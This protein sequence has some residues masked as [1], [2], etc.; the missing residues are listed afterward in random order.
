MLRRMWREYELRNKKLIVFDFDGVILDTFDFAFDLTKQL[1]QK[2]GVFPVTVREDFEEMFEDNPWRYF[3]SKGVTANTLASYQKDF[4]SAFQNAESSL[5]V[6]SE[7]C[8][9]IRKL[10]NTYRLAIVS[11]NYRDIVAW[12]VEKNG[13]KDCFNEI[14]GAEQKGTKKEKLE[15][16]ITDQD[17]RSEESYF[18]TDTSGDIR[19]GQEVGMKTVAVV[20][21]YHGKIRLG[22]VKPDFIANTPQQLLTIFHI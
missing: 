8:D 11:S 14:V 9:V 10:S 6:F 3:E 4:L 20:W 17:M 13:I 2:Y 19:E 16:I 5:L 1:T 7:I 12:Y 21:G 15:K 22:K 18:I